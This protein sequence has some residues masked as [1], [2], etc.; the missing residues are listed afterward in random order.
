MIQDESQNADSRPLIE[1]CD[2][3]KSCE[4]GDYLYL[5]AETRRTRRM[6]KKALTR[7]S[8]VP[9]YAPLRWMQWAI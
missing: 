1:L 3:F 7:R 5:T 6:R 8:G 4:I 2:V 9:A